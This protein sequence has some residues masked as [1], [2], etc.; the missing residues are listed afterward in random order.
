MVELLLAIALVVVF[1]TLAFPISHQMRT[2]FQTV[3]CLS[4]MRQLYGAFMAYAGDNGGMLPPGH[5]MKYFN[6]NELHSDFNWADHLVPN[7]I[8]ASPYC[9]AMRLTPEGRKKYPK[10]KVRLATLAGYSVNFYLL[11]VKMAQLPGP[12]FTSRAYP[13]NHR[14]LFLTESTSS[15]ATWSL[16]HASF[17]LDGY[18]PRYLEPRSHLLPNA[19]NFFF[20]DGH[21]ATLT[22][23][24]G[25]E[26]TA[27]S[28]STNFD[29]WGRDQRYI[30]PNGSKNFDP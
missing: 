17:A 15:G 11:Q 16:E 7:Y 29:S 28:W 5:L 13:G 2:R 26:T 8:G 4:N 1:V 22:R 3:G 10:E 18:S 30:S 25:T 12:H 9:P 19:L 20:L 27:P 6:P 23:K 24:A 14:M 21:A